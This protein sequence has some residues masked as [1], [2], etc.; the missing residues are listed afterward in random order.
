MVVSLSD[1]SDISKRAI[2]KI[3]ENEIEKITYSFVQ[4]E[5]N[6][7]YYDKYIYSSLSK[8]SNKLKNEFSK[9]A[10]ICP[11]CKVEGKLSYVFYRGKQLYCENCELNNKKAFS[12][13][14]RAGYAC[15][16]CSHF[17]P[18]SHLLKNNT[19]P[20]ENCNSL[21]FINEL[22]EASHPTAFRKFENDV[23]YKDEE[24]KYTDLIDVENIIEIIDLE[25]KNL[26]HYGI[27]YT[28][29]HNK[30]VLLAFKNFLNKEP[31][32]FV[33]YLLSYRNGSLCKIFQEYVSIL[34]HNLPIIY[35]KYNNKIEANNLLQL[36]VFNGLSFFES[37]INGLKLNNETI[38]HHNGKQF[39]IGKLINVELDNKSIINEVKCFDFASVEFKNQNFNN[40]K[41][42]ITHYRIFPHYQMGSFVYIHNMKKRIKNRIIES[43]K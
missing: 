36:N 3:I 9:R 39:L 20:Y 11:S 5:H 8:F 17:I 27:E 37:K 43:S 19:C 18:K 33:E 35:K 13:H 38:E 12:F 4:N 42:K 41:V 16:N 31:E 26:N 2:N 29:I 23:V 30:T 15:K 28:R 14:S 21:V 7:S 1:N 25:L 6:F 24:V 22:K 34:E 10:Y 32:L 40:K